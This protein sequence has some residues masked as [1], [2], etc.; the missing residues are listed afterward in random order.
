[1]LRMLAWEG[2]SV[3]LFGCVAGLAMTGIAFRFMSGMIFARWTLDPFAVTGVL[4][5]FA[6]ATLAACFVP[7]RRATKIDPIQ[8]L[9]T[10]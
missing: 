7:G 2:G 4:V 5:T 10:D 9:R 1:V 3:V 6:A 8:L